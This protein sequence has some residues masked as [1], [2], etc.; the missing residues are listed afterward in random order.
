MADA[1]NV[2]VQR[3][4]ADKKE[5]VEVTQKPEAGGVEKVNETS[6]DPD[7]PTGEDSAQATPEDGVKYVRGHPVIRN[8]ECL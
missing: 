5:I 7:L 4:G 3:K 6:S 2:P 1:V 8:G